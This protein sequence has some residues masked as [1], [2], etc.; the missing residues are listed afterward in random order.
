[1]S[2]SMMLNFGLTTVYLSIYKWVEPAITYVY[3][4]VGK[5]GEYG[6]SSMIHQAK[7][8]SLLICQTFFCQMLEKSQFANFPPTKLSCYTVLEY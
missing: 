3:H 2:T 5:F 8:I 6:K 4:I 1:M 7:L